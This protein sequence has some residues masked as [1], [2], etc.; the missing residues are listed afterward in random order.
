QIGEDG[1]WAFTPE[2]PLAE[3]EHVFEVVITDPAG[4]A[5]EPS[6]EFVVIIDTIAPEKPSVGGVT[7]EQGPIASG[8]STDDTQP[9]LNGEG[10]PG[11]TVTIIDNGN[12]IGEVQIGEDGKW[13][14][15]PEAPLA[16]GEHV[17]EVVI[18]DPA[19]NASEPSEEFVVIVDTVAPEK[20]SVG[21]VTGEQGP[22]ASGE[23]TDDTQPTLSGEGNP[24]DTVTIIDNGNVIGEVQIGE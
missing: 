19:G 1:K 11:D 10:N 8:E 12:V 23:S 20:P 9:T 6:D 13:A 4:N 7:G 16:E 14:F 3:G 24:G 2:A 22:I 17:F 18:T 15:T 21:G 5:S